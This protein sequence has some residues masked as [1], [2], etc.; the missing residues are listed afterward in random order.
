MTKTTVDNLICKTARATV[1]AGMAATVVGLSI[2]MVSQPVFAA[3]D[4]N[5]SSA[6][7]TIS[8]TV[9]AVKID[10][11]QIN[12]A[13]FT[14]NAEVG[15]TAVRTLNAK[16]EVHF[17][18]DQDA[19]VVIKQGDK[20]FWEGDT[21]AGQPVTATID[22]TDYQVGVYTFT[23]EASLADTEGSSLVYFHLDYRATI[24][25]IIPGGDVNAP[26]TGL[27]MTIGGRVYSMTTIALI[28]LLAAVMVYLIC[29][30][31][32]DKQEAPVKAKSKSKTTRKKMDM[33]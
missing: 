11:T 32:G 17:K 25:S 19:H 24:P 23:V 7:S 29:R 15:S 8:V 31:M 14:D 3:D 16:N 1:V 9:K 20:V 28:L 6:E 10:V 18:T 2:G 30:K 13:I 22:L 21:K 27:Y 4:A 26:N 12:G 5:T 33:I